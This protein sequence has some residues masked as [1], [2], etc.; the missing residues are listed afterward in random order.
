[1]GTGSAALSYDKSPNDEDELG[2]AQLFSDAACEILAH[3]SDAHDH[4]GEATN[5]HSERGV[6]V[7]LGVSHN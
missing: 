7:L 4:D 5:L 2:G 3:Q 1:M 6:G